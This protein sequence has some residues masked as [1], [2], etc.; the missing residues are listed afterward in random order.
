MTMNSR[1]VSMAIQDRSRL[2]LPCATAPTASF[3]QRATE[4]FIP[5]YQRGAWPVLRVDRHAAAASQS[6]SAVRVGS[7]A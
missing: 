3:L 6:S 7:V 5:K 4:L 1:S 2:L